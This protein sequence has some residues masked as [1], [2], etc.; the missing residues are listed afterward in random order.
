MKT[1][2]DDEAMGIEQWEQTYCA[3]PSEP[4]RINGQTM[5]EAIAAAIAQNPDGASRTVRAVRKSQ[6]VAELRKD[7]RLSNPKRSAEYLAALIRDPHVP[8]G[9][10]QV[11]AEDLVRAHDREAADTAQA[12]RLEAEAAALLKP[13]GTPVIRGGEVARILD[14]EGCEPDWE[15]HNTLYNPDQTGLDASTVR[16]RLLYEAHADLVPLALDAAISAKADNSLEKMLTH[17]N[18]AMYLLTMRFTRRALEFDRSR[19]MYSQ[20]RSQRASIEANRCATT[21]AK[22]FQAMQDGVL[23]LQ[24]LKHG[25]QQTVNVRH[26]DVQP[27]AQAVIGSVNHGGARKDSPPVSLATKPK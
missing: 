25:V 10:L 13:A 6:E 18:A 5:D 1:A 8:R 16:T 2:A 14:G 20:E 22:T 9:Q 12:R 4:V 19:E 27:G 23:T 26:I 24:R 15:L 7:M 21:A 3:V 11:L 17:G